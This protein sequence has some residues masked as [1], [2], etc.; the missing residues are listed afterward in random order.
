M[1]SKIWYPILLGC[2]VGLPS[3]KVTNAQDIV[4]WRELANATGMVAGGINACGNRAVAEGII[5]S[6]RAELD[7]EPFSES[8]LQAIR[9]GFRD[10]LARGAKDIGSF[11][12]EEC[13]EFESIAREL[14]YSW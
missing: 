10:G 6:F 5:T 2:L 1:R 7:S 3:S 4:D 9:S 14:G 11:S 12:E 8:D 13:R